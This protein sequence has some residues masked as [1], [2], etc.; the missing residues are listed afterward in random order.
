MFYCINTY[1]VCHFFLYFSHLN[2]LLGFEL[3]LFYCQIFL[4]CSHLFLKSPSSL[5]YSSSTISLPGLGTL[6]NSLIWIKFGTLINFG[7][8]FVT[9]CTDIFRRRNPNPS[10]LSLN[11]FSQFWTF[12]LFSKHHIQG[13]TLNTFKVFKYKM[14]GVK[15]FKYRVFQNSSTHFK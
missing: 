2:C 15:V 3:T 14:T 13:W 1:C 11:F 6:V 9:F 7:I 4:C 8:A 12:S 10:P 5:N